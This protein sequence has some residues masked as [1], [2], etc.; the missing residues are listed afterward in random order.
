VHDL[1]KQLVAFDLD[2]QRKQNRGDLGVNDG[3]LAGIA[4]R[5]EQIRDKMTS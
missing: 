4:A 3:T 5:L 2:N 1:K